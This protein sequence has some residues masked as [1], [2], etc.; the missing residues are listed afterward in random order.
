[1]AIRETA[2]FRPKR[3]LRHSGGFEG[4]GAALEEG[5]PL[6]LSITKQPDPSE[7]GVQF[8]SVAP[9]ECMSIGVMS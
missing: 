7:S 8:D 2:A 1:V 5:D 6:D 3:L 4:V 9:S